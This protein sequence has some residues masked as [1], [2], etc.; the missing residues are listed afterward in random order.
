[1]N[2]RERMDAAMRPAHGTPDRVPVM[3]QLAIGHYF[4]NTDI[5]PAEIWHDSIAFA[6]ALVTLQRRYQFDGI[7]VNL[8]GRDPEWRD[9]IASTE[10]RSDRTIIR[11][12]EG[13]T[14][15]VPHDDNAR[16][17]SQRPSLDALD[18]DTIFYIEPHD[19]LGVT[20]LRAFPRWQFDTLRR[21][22]ALAPGISVHGEV[23]SPFSQMVDL[24]GIT[25]AMLAIVDDPNKVKACLDRLVAGTIELGRGLGTAGADAILISSAYAGAGFISRAHYEQFV[26]PYEKRVVDGIGG[27]VYTH[28]C[29]AIGDRLDLMERSGTRGIDT[30]DPPP[31]GTVDLAEARRRLSANVFIK[32][33]I[34]PVNTVLRGTP[35]SCYRDALERIAIAG[36]RGYIVSTACSVPPRAP[37]E[38]VMAI[39][40]AA[41][42]SVCVA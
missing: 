17:A 33:N 3:C 6:E 35:E 14:T 4:L 29:G 9:H 37:A 22:R 39:A 16:V 23:F 13:P 19:R 30:L 10:E 38:N 15:I 41:K 25:D 18:P 32:G 24:L 34:D 36:P 40:R 11:W 5:P 27:I 7:L 26:L 20:P 31:L 21:V 8:P 42:E 2:C 12:K 28:T 1:M